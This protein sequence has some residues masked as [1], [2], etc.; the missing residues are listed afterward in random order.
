MATPREVPGWCPLDRPAVSDDEI[1][2]V[3]TAAV[4]Q[5]RF[6]PDVVRARWPAIRVAL[7]GFSLRTVASWPD[8]MAESLAARPGV[9][10]NGK[11]LRAVIRNA[12]DLEARAREFGSAL[13]YL[14]SFRPDPEAL[15]RGLDEWAHYVGAPSLRWFVR[16]AGVT[17]SWRGEDRPSPST[18][19]P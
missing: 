9:I 15:V 11:K 18:D 12:R 14:D 10:R 6:R 7:E 2:E 19:V 1:F 13:A 3:L 8:E 4:F 17:R 5:A 16:C